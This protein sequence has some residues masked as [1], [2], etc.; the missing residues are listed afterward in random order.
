ML[1]KI[2]ARR[3]SFEAVITLT[4]TL[5]RIW[6][7]RMPLQ[8]R[9]LCRS[10]KSWLCPQRGRI[11]IKALICLTAKYRAQMAFLWRFCR[12][13]NQHSL[14][15]RSY[16]GA[17]SGYGMGWDGLGWAGLGWAGLGCLTLHAQEPKTKCSES[18]AGLFKAG[19]R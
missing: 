12:M 19:L 6:S 18:W 9:P 17:G 15:T 4:Y 13:R 1:S 16:A 2:L 8:T 3:W 7:A 10:K 14:A 5:W 11:S